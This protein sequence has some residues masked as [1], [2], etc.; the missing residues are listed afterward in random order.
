M[1]SHEKK[2][3]LDESIEFFE[4]FINRVLPVAGVTEG[5]ENV[6]PMA[7]MRHYNVIRQELAT[8]Y[9]DLD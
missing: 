1:T 7:I 6:Q 9:V 3:A 2:K 4:D 8:L 5:L